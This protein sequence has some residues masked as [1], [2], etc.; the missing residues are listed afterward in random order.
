MEAA[1]AFREALLAV[2]VFHD[3]HWMHRDLKPANIGIIGKPLRCILLD[4]GTSVYLKPGHG[5][6]PNPG[7]RGTLNYL[8]PERELG[9]YDLS[10]DI[11]AMGVILYQLTYGHHPWKF[12]INPWRDEEENEKLRPEFRKSYQDVIDKM[13][14]DY[15]SAHQSPTQ[16][17]IHRRYSIYRAWS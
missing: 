12:A 6:Q 13:T 4:T 10:V 15:Q 8:A 1:G 14:A 2:K 17:Y 9:K 16:G 3:H 11:W 7:H 5:L